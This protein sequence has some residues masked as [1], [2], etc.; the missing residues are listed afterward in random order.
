MNRNYVTVILCHPTVIHPLGCQLVV[1]Q[2]T[3]INLLSWGESTAGAALAGRYLDMLILA[4][5]RYT[6][7]YSQGAVGGRSMR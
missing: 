4:R 1:A 2:G 3:V 7:R 5:S 6:Q